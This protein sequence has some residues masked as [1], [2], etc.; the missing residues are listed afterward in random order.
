MGNEKI[1][2]IVVI[3][4]VLGIS[5]GFLIPAVMSERTIPETGQAEADVSP[6]VTPLIS[7]ELT[8]LISVRGNICEECHVS[9]KVTA[10]QA[11]TIKDHIE[12][13]NYCLKCH[14]ISHENHRVDGNVTCKSCH[15]GVKPKVPSPDDGSI[16]CGNCH[17]YPD[18]L[19][20]SNGN[21]ASIHQLRGINCVSCHLDCERCHEQAP[22]GKKW[23][24]RLNHFNTLPN[25][26]K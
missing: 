15:G 5:L 25:T 3:F 6:E 12:G 19:L 20:P 16:L 13:G 17:A 18:A 22:I 26:Y 4:G 23:D 11:S 2:Y 24:R 21:L 8:L 10:P 9:G 7:N 1:I 14:T